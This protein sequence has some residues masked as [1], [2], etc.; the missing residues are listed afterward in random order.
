MNAIRL[1][2][3][4]TGI[5]RVGFVRNVTCGAM[6]LAV[7]ALQAPTAHAIGGQFGLE[8]AIDAPWRLEPIASD[9][10]EPQ[11]GPIPIV[12][13]FH[14]AIFEDHRGQLGSLVIDRIHV[15]TLKEIIVTER[16]RGG[17]DN[18]STRIDPSQ[19]REIERKMWISTVDQEPPH[20][21]CTPFTG[22]NC[23]DLY[24][25]SQS[26]EWH[27]LF[28]YTPKEAVTPGRNIHLEVTV[29]TEGRGISTGIT[30]PIGARKEWRNYLVIHAGEAP[31]PR[32]SNQWLYGDLHYHSQMTDNEGESAYA[33]R[34]VVRALGALG[35]DFVFATD[36]ASSSTQ[37]FADVS[38]ARCSVSFRQC[39]PIIGV[40]LP[41]G[42]NEGV[43]LRITGSEARDLNS[44]RFQ[45]AKSIL[46]GINGANEDVATD[47]AL[48]GIAGYHSHG[49]LPQIFMGEEIDAWPEMSVEE[50]LRGVIEFGDGLKYRWADSDN[51]L[52]DPVAT[53]ATC[54]ALYSIPYT[55]TTSDGTI[56]RD[57]R[58]YLVRDNQGIPIEESIE[59]RVGNKIAR[60]VL[61]VYAPDGTKSLPSRQHL[62]Y[63]PFDGTATARGWVPGNTGEFGGASRTLEDLLPD[64]AQNGRAFLAHPMIGKSPDGF[65]PNVVPYSDIAL[66]RAWSSPAILGLQFW[67]EDSRRKSAPSVTR[68]YFMRDDTTIDAERGL[69]THYFYDLPWAQTDIG[70]Y[71]WT[72]RG[73]ALER[74]GVLRDLYHG[75]FT[76]DR[77]LRKGLDPEI[78]SPLEWLRG[79]PRKWFMAGGSDAHGDLNYR[80]EGRPGCDGFERWCDY[81][82][83]DTAIGKP[84]NLVLVGEPLGE[85]VPSLGIRR[86]TNSQVIDALSAGRFSVTDGPALRIAVDRN[87]NGRIDDDDFQM[88]ETFHLYPKE[89]IP[90]LVEWI[91]TEEFG[92]VKNIDVYV[93]TKTSTYAPKRHGVDAPERMRNVYAE[94]PS[95]VLKVDLSQSENVSR[96]KSQA[97]L[98]LSPHQFGIRSGND[99]FY[100][101]AFAETAPCPDGSVGSR[102]TLG[103]G[104]LCAHR[105][106]YSNPIWGIYHTG[107]THPSDPDAKWGI[108]V[109]GD[110][111]ADVCDACPNLPGTETEGTVVLRDNRLVD[112]AQ[113]CGTVKADPCPIGGVSTT[114]SPVNSCQVI[115]AA[116]LAP[117]PNIFEVT[118][119]H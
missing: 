22:A 13:S 26:H 38:A 110:S 60:G 4:I 49:V 84:R 119:T 107:C 99:R 94:D 67:N 27:A 71:P 62:V 113:A 56:V 66:D 18:P 63:F 16:V 51:C 40:P 24:E 10:P 97:K 72:W 102:L 42:G 39:H 83:S 8:F 43:C 54:R 117:L 104:D 98:Y 115:E 48:R 29:I 91:S 77:Y 6:V 52:A 89:R 28:W 5:M 69:V 82:V 3:P 31:L 9:A 85:P 58:R 70:R 61:S 118:P 96:Y 80:R 108:D 109:D 57:Q 68:P 32:F 19:L 81:P 12:I 79:Q 34:S 73:F 50:Q 14:D 30:E 64:I 45:H 55:H 41:C 112:R 75:A 17:P 90:L 47:I 78:T 33:Y 105:F 2:A 92:P 37:V 86:H 20:E 46:Y 36:H 44:T 1:Y 25:I 87:R 116:R 59:D 74:S 23:R 76:W 88:G 35:M 106:A 103:G 53:L 11:Y 100:L 114:E 111:H 93:G 101:R 7:C 21:R 65:G 15:G 95:G